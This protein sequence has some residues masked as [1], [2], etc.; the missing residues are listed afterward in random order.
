MRSA[1]GFLSGFVL[2]LL[3]AV[4]MSASAQTEFDPVVWASSP[5]GIEQISETFAAGVIFPLM[6][7]AIGFA[8]GA[9]LRMIGGR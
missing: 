1:L 5:E 2:V 4:S 3:L 9:I 8:C 7:Y 6:G